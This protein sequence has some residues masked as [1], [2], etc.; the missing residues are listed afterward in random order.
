MEFFSESVSNTINLGEKLGKKL[1]GGEFI[2]LLGDLGGGKTHFA[3]GLANGLGVE[4]RITSPTFVIERIYP[5]EKGSLH[6]FD[7][8]RMSG[9]EPEIEADLKEL[10][11]GSEDI[12]VVE[13]AKNIPQVIPAERLEIIF[14]YID[15]NSRKLIF[16][17][18]GERYHKL[19]KE[20]DK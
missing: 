8:Y 12:V 5:L 6:H 13:W 7:F 2:A 18:K 16:S 10:K 9:S 17:A 1:T 3:K 20:F 4:E 15:E 14:E 11:A 19:L